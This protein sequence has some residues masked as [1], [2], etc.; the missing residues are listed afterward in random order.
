MSPAAL[1]LQANFFFLAAEPPEKTGHYFGS[2]TK[3]GLFHWSIFLI[4]CKWCFIGTLKG[5]S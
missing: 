4:I 3:P 1:E 5:I 2:G